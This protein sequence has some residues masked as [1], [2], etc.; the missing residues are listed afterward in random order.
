MLIILTLLIGVA[1]LDTLH[2]TLNK[3][4]DYALENNIEIEQLQVGFEKSQAQVGE[5]LSA[6]YPSVNARGGYA[7]ITDIPVIDFEGMSVP[8]SFG[9]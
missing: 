2:F 6:F 5:A 7:Y 3:A 1:N 8:L 9:Y 4:I